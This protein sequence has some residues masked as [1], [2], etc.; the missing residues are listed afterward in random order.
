MDTWR[1]CLCRKTENSIEISVCLFGG[2]FAKTHILEFEGQIYLTFFCCKSA[3]WPDWLVSLLFCLLIFPKGH[4]SEAVSPI[5]LYCS[6]SS[7]SGHLGFRESFVLA[8]SFIHLFIYLF[9]VSASLEGF[10][11][12]LAEIAPFW[13][14]S[15]WLSK[16]PA[17]KP[18][19]FSTVFGL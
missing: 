8:R 10:Q 15:I 19:C 4:D 6:I 13:R 18:R 7:P 17:A 9:F 2:Q 16:T 5:L 1:S 12:Q 3:V 11:G 14:S